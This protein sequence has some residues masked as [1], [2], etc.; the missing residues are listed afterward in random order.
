M[1]SS[2]QRAETQPG[3]K[4]SAFAL[5]MQAGQNTADRL[6][7]SVAGKQYSGRCMC[8]CNCGYGSEETTSTTRTKASVFTSFALEKNVTMKQE[9]QNIDFA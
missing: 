8:A 9:K 3:N 6:N 1:L 5:S 7:T 2:N 4:T